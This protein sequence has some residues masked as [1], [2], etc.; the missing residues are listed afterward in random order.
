[1]P[2]NTSPPAGRARSLI[3]ALAVVILLAGGLRFWDLA[4]SSLQ[5][6]EQIWHA[7]ASKYM[8]SILGPFKPAGFKEFKF[9]TGNLKHVDLTKKKF[10]L[11]TGYPFN[12]RIIA[13]HPGAPITFLTG[14]AYLF[15]AE[16]SGPWSLELASLI[17]V[18]RWPQALLG[19]IWVLFVFL[20]TR[21]L[22]GPRAAFLAALI[23]AVEPMAVGYSRLARIDFSA[24]VWITG[25][26]WA[27]LTARQE[28]DTR[29]GVLAGVFLGLGVATI[30]FAVTVLAGLIGIKL[31]Y[32]AR[33]VGARRTGW[34]RRLSPDRSDWLLIGAS[35]ATYVVVFPNLW[36]NPVLGFWEVLR[37]N[38]DTPHAK[39]S[40]H[41]NQIALKFFFLI[42]SP[43]HLLPTTVALS[44][45]GLGLGW[46]KFRPGWIVSGLWAGG[47]IFL[48]S[49]PPGL[50][51][52]KNF[53]Q[54]LPAVIVLASLGAVLM[55]EFVGRWFKSVSR[56]R[57]AL[58]L[59][60]VLLA[61]GLGTT[62]HWWPYPRLY[63]WPWQGDPQR[64]SIKEVTAA[65]EGV[66]E[67]IEYMKREGPPRAKMMWITGARIARYYY[68]PKLINEHEFEWYIDS[69]SV[70]DGRYDWVAVRPKYSIFVKGPKGTL[71]E[72]LQQHEPHH[73]I[74][75]H[76]VECV[77]L[78][79]FGP[80][81][82]ERPS[83]EKKKK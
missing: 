51:D 23:A 12:I 63:T 4:G 24:A 57:A 35:L 36:P 47:A 81:G 20:L 6:D 1:M 44:L 56:P 19:T 3:M 27:Y 17:E 62:I 75:H 70:R 66:M 32:P 45:V 60:V 78:Y 58:G 46:R 83:F 39:A 55:V 11:H 25:A 72:W 82:Y 10:V 76:Q 59:A 33:P 54:V 29:F 30:P 48:L 50:R 52:A 77:R 61:F 8:A 67:A 2:E 9:Y 26:M 14:L 71:W 5:G 37:I 49:V 22:I 28:E 69:N 15:F 74:Y 73:I 38:L 65:G 64:H 16:E 40:Q 42:K 34:W 7:R 31:A 18:A 43:A 80:G 13:P 68:D 79:K 41:L 53:V 21:R